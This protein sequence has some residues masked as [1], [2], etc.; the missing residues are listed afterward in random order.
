MTTPQLWPIFIC[1]RRAD[2]I[3]SARRLHE[4]LDK[5]KTSGPDGKPIQLDVYLDETMPGVDFKNSRVIG[6]SPTCNRA[7]FKSRRMGAIFP[8]RGI[9][10]NVR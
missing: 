1:Y 5:W 3:T 10:Q 8:R 6:Y 2:G 4:I 9:S 7:K